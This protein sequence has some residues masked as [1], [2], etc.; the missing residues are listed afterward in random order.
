MSVM[1]EF[2]YTREITIREYLPLLPQ[3]SSKKKSVDHEIF[4]KFS[5]IS[6]EVDR[7]IIFDSHVETS[8]IEALEGKR[9]LKI[10]DQAKK[11]LIKTQDECDL[12]EADPEKEDF[13]VQYRKNISHLA[14]CGKRKN[15][16]NSITLSELALS[17]LE[18]PAEELL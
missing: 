18:L 8:R 1:E 4:N 13:M 2:L 12:L 3:P 11:F 14:T 16:I 6:N 15:V 5:H 17:Q 10:F 9:R 7:K